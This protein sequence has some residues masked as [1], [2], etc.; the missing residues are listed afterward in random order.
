[1][2]I[3]QE[4]KTA[5]L[6]VGNLLLS[7]EGIGVHVAKKLLAEYS[8]PD[9]VDV[10][11]GGVTGMMGLL[12]IIEESDRL[13]V[14]DA[15]DGPGKPG[16]LYR[17]TLDDFRLF[18]PKKLSAH[19]VGLLECL[20]IAEVNGRSPETVTV[21]GVKP[22]DIKTYS[23]DLTSVISSKVG[24][25]AGMVMEELRAMGIEIAKKAPSKI[26]RRKEN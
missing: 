21:I 10:Y 14:I 15:I 12:P 25:L 6:G 22:K 13:I 9:N 26:Y 4:F 7:D 8:F 20:T 23:M 1:M 11:D 19:D 18:I 17:Y 2:E 24:D 5:V 3:N 16:E